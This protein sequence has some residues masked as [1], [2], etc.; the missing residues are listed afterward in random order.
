MN[1]GK[2]LQRYLCRFTLLFGLLTV[3][4]SPAEARDLAGALSIYTIN[5]EKIL[6]DVAR[7]TETGFVELRAANPDVDPWALKQGDRLLIP[8]WHILPQTRTPGLV[9]NLGDMRLYY[10]SDDGQ[11]I[12]SWPVGIGRDGR[13]TPLGEIRVTELREKPTWRPGKNMRD[14]N[15]DLPAALPPGPNNPLGDYAIR[16]GWDEYAIHGTNKPAGVGRRVSSG[17]IRLYPRGIKEVFSLAKVGMPVTIV[18]EP[19]KLGWDKGALYIEAHP[20]GRQADQIEATGRFDPSPIDLTN[21]QKQV[22][23]IAED[24]HVKRLNWKIFDQA[25]AQRRGIPVKFSD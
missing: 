8:G 15:P 22:L 17:C 11:D 9:I 23:K 25:L 5:G 3:C 24:H 19:V 4:V 1:T 13:K 14:A 2:L 12:R 7:E 18:D 16:I 6:T 20:S 21:L 10:F